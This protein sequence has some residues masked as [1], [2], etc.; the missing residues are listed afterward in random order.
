MK[1][2]FLFFTAVSLLSVMSAQ[3]TLHTT[4]PLE[5]YYYNDWQNRQLGDT[6]VC[7]VKIEYGPNTFEGIVMSTKGDDE[8]I[9]IYGL[10]FGVILEYVPHAFEDYIWDDD[11]RCYKGVGPIGYYN[12][13]GEWHLI[14]DS[15]LDESYMDFF[16]MKATA[17]HHAQTVSDTVRLHMMYD[18]AAYYIDQELHDYIPWF[19]CH[20]W[21]VYEMY[22][23][24][25]PT[26]ANKFYIGGVNH[27]AETTN[28]GI[29]KY[30]IINGYG[31]GATNETLHT[32]NVIRWPSGECEESSGQSWQ[33]FFP[34]LTP[35]DNGDTSIIVPDDST[36]TSIRTGSWERYVSL[37]PNPASDEATVLSS[38][39]ID[40]VEV[41]DMG[42]ASVLR[43]QASGLA[44]RLD[45]KALPR[46]TYMVRIHTPLGVTSRKL[47][48]Q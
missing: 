48:L 45:V 3:D 29:Q 12:S 9:T 30:P 43:Q 42:G 21:P 5:N 26:V 25:P 47:I 20:A 13:N 44:A 4:Q 14:G 38:F 24:N 16:V 34:I 40:E 22:F 7:D 23:S 41:Y 37:Q 18:T 36:Q 31:W 15:A 6:V 10:A 35:A 33:W 32:T 8:G 19:A 28:N 17:N 11:C 2:I 46:G 27:S 1:K 39:G